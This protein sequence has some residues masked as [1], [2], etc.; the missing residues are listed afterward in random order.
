MGTSLSMT[1]LDALGDHVFTPGSAW[2]GIVPEVSF[3]DDRGIR[4]ADA[5][6]FWS[7][8]ERWAVEIK[9]GMKPLLAELLTPEKFEMWRDYAHRFVYLLPESIIEDALEVVPAE[10][11]V[12]SALDGYVVHRLGAWNSSPLDVPVETWTRIA[13][14]SGRQSHMLRRQGLPS[15]HTAD[16]ART[17]RG[18]SGQE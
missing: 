7:R 6:L 17:G 2:R 11:G 18:R 12:I 13:L 14:R 3:R 4:R 1:M 5:L 9:S 10:I 16:A 8:E 15:Y